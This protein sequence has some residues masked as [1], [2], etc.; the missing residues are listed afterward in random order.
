[1]GRRHLD[2]EVVDR[3]PVEVGRRSFTL[4][5]RA[6]VILWLLG[7]LSHGIKRLLTRAH[8]LAVLGLATA[9]LYGGVVLV[10][11]VALVLVAVLAAWRLIDPDTFRRR[12]PQRL[13]GLWRWL[14]VYGPRWDDVLSS[15]K[16][17]LVSRHRLP[18]IR[19]VRATA[20]V[21]VLRV[22]MLPGQLL[23]DWVDVSDRI[24]VG[25]DCDEDSCRVATAVKWRPV[26]L[27]ERIP[28]PSRVRRS[29]LHLSFVHRDPLGEV[30]TA[31]PAEEVPDFKALPV[32]LRED[33]SWW[34]LR[35]LGQHLFIAG[36]TGA[37]KGSVLWSIVHQLSPAVRTGL[38]K[39]VGIDPKGGV[40]LG[41]GQALFA[42]FC[43]GRSTEEVSPEAQFADVLERY[44]AEMRTRQDAMFGRQRLH[45]P[46]VEDPFIVVVIDELASLVAAA[47]Q[48]D[49]DA[50]KRIIA[51]I[52][53]LLSQGRAFGITV[54]G[55][56]QDPRKE[57]VP[58]R[59]LFTTRVALRLNEAADVPLVL[60]EGA[61]DRGAWCDK[62]R[63]DRQGVGYAIPESSPEPIRMR[64]PFHS[65]EA[66]AELARTHAAPGN[67]QLVAEVAELDPAA[68]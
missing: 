27:P 5:L 58:M 41:I 8:W 68:A 33:G 20:G 4:S 30:V 7:R 53:L 1:M 25:F 48:S 26:W 49:K 28:F 9:H 52:N 60:G 45:K 34:R 32:A 59:G 62:I 57:S 13:R 29:D 55:A 6:Q 51:A 64:F 11:V 65:D 50:G 16:V 43:R 66:I 38:V 22:R 63:A 44:V 24:A 15:E 39:L 46:T 37:G 19:F 31:H 18:R 40:E 54:V 23:R 47:Y 36:A 2:G 61:R 14:A 67:L 12:I 10:V 3:G 42:D 56:V 35:L 17:K 21:D